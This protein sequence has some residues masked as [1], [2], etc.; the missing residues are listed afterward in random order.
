MR[1]MKLDRFGELSL[2]LEVFVA[3][4]LYPMTLTFESDHTLALFVIRRN[5]FT[6]GY[7]W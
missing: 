1:M 4:L 5:E 2:D 7:T 6:P 3:S